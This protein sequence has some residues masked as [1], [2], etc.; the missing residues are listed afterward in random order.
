MPSAPV[1]Y[2]NSP[3]AV[4]SALGMA[5][6]WICQAEFGPAFPKVIV[7]RAYQM[8]DAGCVGLVSSQAVLVSRCVNPLRRGKCDLGSRGCHVDL[9]KA[10]RLSCLYIGTP[11]GR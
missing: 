8:S 3:S 9:G 6:L 1:P 11:E 5:L 7:D 2:G 10:V 4:S